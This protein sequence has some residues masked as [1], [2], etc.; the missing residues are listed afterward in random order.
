MKYP[1]CSGENLKHLRLLKDYSQ[2][3]I[4]RKLGI[5]QPA[6]SK[7]EKRRKVNDAQ[8]EKILKIMHCDLKDLE[9]IQKV[10]LL[11]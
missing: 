3:G 2:K 9:N 11:K 6:Y 7:M 4:A 5:S 8:L 1:L 10:L